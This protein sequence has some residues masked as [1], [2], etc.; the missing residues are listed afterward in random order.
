M[1]IITALIAFICGVFAGA[2]MA[3]NEAGRHMVD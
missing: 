1:R 3:I 2:A